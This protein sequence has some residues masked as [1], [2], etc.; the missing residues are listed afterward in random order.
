MQGELDKNTI[1]ELNRCLPE[2]NAS[3]I[4]ISKFNLLDFSHRFKKRLQDPVFG[5]KGN[6]DKL[7][8]PKIK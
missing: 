4:Q 6:L 5:Q 8:L 1:R 2:L 3:S 7:K